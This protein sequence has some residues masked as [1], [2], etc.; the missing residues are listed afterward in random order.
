LGLPLLQTPF[1][2]FRLVS[3]VR[4]V[5]YFPGASLNCAGL[6]APIVRLLDDSTR[7][8]FD[9]GLPR[10]GLDVASLAR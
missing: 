2:T 7:R 8:A 9:L 4:P 3:Y 10:G 1:R 6:P 5:S